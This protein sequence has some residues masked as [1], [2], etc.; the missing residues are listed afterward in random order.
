MVNGGSELQREVQQFQ[1]PGLGVRTNPRAHSC[2][3]C[4]RFGA[5]HLCVPIHPS[6]AS[7]GT[8]ASSSGAAE[9][10]AKA[11]LPQGLLSLQPT[12]EPTPVA[13]LQKLLQGI[14]SN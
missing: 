8:S 2:L 5:N 7:T 6:T 9:P 4:A 14:I 11:Q 1:A 13:T 3:V 12:G 10:R